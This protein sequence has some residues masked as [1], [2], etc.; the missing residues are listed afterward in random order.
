LQLGGEFVESHCVRP[1]ILLPHC[2]W[3]LFERNQAA[4][5]KAGQGAGDQ[6]G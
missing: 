6:A 1:W 5:S 2:K 3:G 4:Y